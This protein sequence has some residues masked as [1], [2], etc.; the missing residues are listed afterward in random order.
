MTTPTYTNWSQWEKIL[1]RFFFLLL[2][3]LTLIAYNPLMQVLGIGYFQQR[4]FFGNLKGVA[5]WLD[6]HVF[7]LGYQPAR[8]SIDFSDTHFGVIL[9]FT[10]LV[11]A[12]ISAVLWTLSD[13]TRKNYNRLYYWFSNYLAYYIF[14][15]MLPYAIEKII[16][17]QAP[18]P[19]ATELISRWG[20]LRRWEVLFRFMGTGQLY[21]MF[22][23]WLE[24]VAS[25]LILFN[26]TRVIGGLL[27]T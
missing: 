11:I 7:H 4:A 8:Y 10:I 27:L 21:C 20:D 15:A 23:G 25:L 9:T 22:C 2:L 17:V 1:F 18:Y 6:A 3:T 24:F 26:R 13:K 12:L 14:L 5:A 16:P 19:T